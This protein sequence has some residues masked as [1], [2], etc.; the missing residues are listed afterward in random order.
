MTRDVTDKADESDRI[1]RRLEA[2]DRE[3][4][5]LQTRLDQLQKARI[6]ASRVRSSHPSVTNSP[7]AVEKI[8]LFR[9]LFGGRKHVFP[10]RW[11]NPKTG[12]SGYA[13]ACAN[14]WAR[15]VCGK[16]QV[17]CGDCPNKAFIPV[18]SDVIECRLR[19]EDHI[20]PNGRGK[21]F[22]ADVSRGSSTTRADSWPSTST[23]RI[24]P[25]TP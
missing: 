7:P 20:R 14:E 23:R 15:G 17:K 4:L 1:Q 9:R 3:R 10:A 24:G 8:A 5:L 2:L 6:D 25:A 12:R 18:T 22:V 21:D 19:G 16:P 11:D 13:P